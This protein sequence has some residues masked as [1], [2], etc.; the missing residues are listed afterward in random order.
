MK[1]QVRS[2]KRA[3]TEPPEDDE[4]PPTKKRKAI[5]HKDNSVSARAAAAGKRYTALY[6]AWGSREAIFDGFR[7][8]ALKTGAIQE[9]SDESS[10]DDDDSSSSSSE[11]EGPGDKGVKK[12]AVKAA[13]RG[14]DGD[15]ENDGL[16]DF[17]DTAAQE[18]YT[19]ASA[20]QFWQDA[21]AKEVKGWQTDGYQTRVSRYFREW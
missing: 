6:D 19:K 1:N 15:E 3:S 9:E 8:A 18:A 14:A 13:G 10:E 17:S 2:L 4:E 5:K 21:K 12:G 16:Y 7:A 11:D 20:M